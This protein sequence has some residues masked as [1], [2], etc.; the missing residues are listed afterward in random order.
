MNSR[1]IGL[2]LGLE[3]GIEIGLESGMEMGLE[4]GLE[5]EK[6]ASFGYASI[7]PAKLG[8]LA[9]GKRGSAL[10]KELR[11]T[12]PSLRFRRLIPPIGARADIIRCFLWVC[13][14]QLF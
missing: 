3:S 9:H 11:P 4:F 1:G 14:L 2:E 6:K 7:A 10:P 5:I 13:G 8:Q 12:Q